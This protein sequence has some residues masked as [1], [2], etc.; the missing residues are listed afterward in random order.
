M[1]LF[2]RLYIFVLKFNYKFG[3]KFILMKNGENGK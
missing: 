1:Y 2:V 3:I